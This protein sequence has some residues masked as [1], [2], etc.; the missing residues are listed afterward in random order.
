MSKKAPEKMQ[1]PQ[2]PQLTAPTPI[3]ITPSRAVGMIQADLKEAGKY[4]AQMEPM[5]V[6]AEAIKKHL[7]GVV[8]LVEELHNAQ[9]QVQAQQGEMIKQAQMAKQAANANGDAS[10]AVN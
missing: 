4:F 9:L 1:A 10:K 3:H 6:D 7:L 2:A 8:R 5:A